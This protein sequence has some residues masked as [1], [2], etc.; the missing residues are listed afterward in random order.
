MQVYSMKSMFSA[1]PLIV[2][3]PYLRRRRGC[4]GGQRME[5]FRPPLLRRRP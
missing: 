3:V 2:I 4:S 1:A 5:P